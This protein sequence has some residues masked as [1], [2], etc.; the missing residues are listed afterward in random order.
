M[1]ILAG[2]YISRG[3][4]WWFFLVYLFRGIDKA[5]E[6]WYTG[7][8]RPHS[9]VVRRTPYASS[10]RL[11]ALSLALVSHP[12]A[13]ARTSVLRLQ[14]CGCLSTAFGCSSSDYRPAVHILRM[15][16][17]CGARKPHSRSL[18]L[19]STRCRSLVLG[20]SSCACSRSADC[21]RL[22]EAVLGQR[23]RRAHNY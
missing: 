1:L 17:S 14:P 13:C 11:Y 3:L 20:L 4:Y 7:G 16:V 15:R 8:G 10:S 22:K 19:P 18:S 6:M 21:L 12:L 2:A 23:Q 9:S 5:T